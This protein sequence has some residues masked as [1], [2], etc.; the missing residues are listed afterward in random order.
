MGIDINQEV[1]KAGD[2]MRRFQMPR[3]AQIEVVR[4]IMAC[5]VEH[6]LNEQERVRAENTRL[7]AKAQMGMT[8]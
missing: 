6:C 7:I 3:D 4:I 8:N 2:I 5:G 1:M